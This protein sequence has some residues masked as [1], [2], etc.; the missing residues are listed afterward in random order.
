MKIKNYANY[1]RRAIL[2][3]LLFALFAGA[4]SLEKASA[5]ITEIIAASNLSPYVSSTSQYF[6]SI[7]T[8]LTE[9]LSLLMVSSS[10]LDA[11]IAN[12]ALWID[13]QSSFAQ[14]GLNITLA[15][16]DIFLIVVFIAIAMAYVFKVESFRAQKTL[17]KFFAVALLIHF[18]PLF[19][20]M[21]TDVANIIVSGITANSQSTF[22]PTFIDDLGV[23]IGMSILPLIANLNSAASSSLAGVFGVA[24]N[25]ASFT[26]ATGNL[27][28]SA[29]D[30]I[31]R[32][33]ILKL[34]AVLVFG[35]AVFFTARIFIIQALTV[36][37]PLAVLCA[38]L[39]QTKQYF[40]TWKQWLLGWTFGGVLL[41]FL[42]VLGLNSLGTFSLPANTITSLS[43]GD[44]TISLDA[45]WNFKWISL[46]IYIIAMD[47]ICMSIIPI[48]NAKMKS[49]GNAIKKINQQITTVVGRREQET[50]KNVEAIPR[51]A[52]TMDRPAAPHQV[53]PP[54]DTDYPTGAAHA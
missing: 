17:P 16:A 11:A 25:F 20:G 52:A 31:A 47:M 51:S 21:A 24:A 1:R 43:L 23:S 5:Q 29:P 39:P 15:L 50:K 2:C 7:I 26:M 6:V 49:S 35:H 33:I 8:Q 45:G 30:Y 14:T 32:I 41:L 4:P 19:V 42:L 22:S 13:I 9:G 54:P 3:F 12:S 48:F 38:A 53:P 40:D 28:L 36:L 34:T 46:A 27:I 44:K 37:S 18:A 10:V